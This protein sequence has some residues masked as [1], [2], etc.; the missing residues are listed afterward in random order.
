MA[1]CS[2]YPMQNMENQN[3]FDLEQALREWREDCA[4]RP[5]ISFDNA[6]ELESDLR[7]RVADLLKQGL[8]E[9]EAF[10]RAVRQV[11]SPAELAREFAREHPLAVWRERL[12]WIVAAG[13][14]ASVWSLLAGG[15]LLW[16]VN[17]FCEALPFSTA[18]WLT[19]GGNLPLLV[20][21]VLLATGRVPNVLTRMRFFGRRHLAFAGT[22]LLAVGLAVRLFG[23]YPLTAR[24]SLLVKAVGLS[25]EPLILLSLGVSL[26]RP[27][28]RPESPE[29]I[30]CP[31]WVSAVVWR[32][33]VFWMATGAL[34]GGLWQ[35]VTVLCMVATLL[36]IG[37][38]NTLGKAWFIGSY[39]LLELSPL[40]VLGLLL[41]HRMRS[42]KDVTAGRLVR[43]RAMFALI[44][45]VVCAW[46]TLTLWSNHYWRPDG[47]HI[48]WSTNVANYFMTLRWFWPAGLAFLILWL[49]PR[50]QTQT[51]RNLA[52][53]GD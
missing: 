47:V 41:R 34:A 46:A 3:R 36:H 53:A 38:F 1:Q 23:P 21:A 11:G 51:S 16:F 13:F 33:R 28:A 48:S 43:S 2:Q 40:L 42:G 30:S 15:V 10:S 17:T 44:P 24:E 49:A 6:R 27:F 8:N 32:E 39:L 45:V 26:F 29:S 50:G 4:S 37:D 19:L 5:G 20:L 9:R 12:F 31:S 14:T 35:A 18:A 52:P 25:L 22:S 7:E